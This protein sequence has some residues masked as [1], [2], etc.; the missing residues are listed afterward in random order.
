MD[1]DRLHVINQVHGFGSGNK[2]IERAAELLAQSWLPSAALS[3]R[4]SSDQF[5]MVLPGRRTRRPG[6]ACL[7]WHSDLEK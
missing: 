4:V 3:A 7:S 5:T 2:V 1:I 6:R